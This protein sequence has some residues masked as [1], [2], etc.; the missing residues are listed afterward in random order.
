LNELNN[1]IID[2]CWHNKLVAI[3]PIP[4]IA[5]QMDGYSNIVKLPKSYRGR[6]MSSNNDLVKF[7]K[8]KN[9]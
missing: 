7:I 1:I 6:I 8:N 3:I 4:F 9:N 5:T 2:K